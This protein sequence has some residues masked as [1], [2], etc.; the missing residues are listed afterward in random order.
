M[1]DANIRMKQQVQKSNRTATVRRS[2]RKDTT[3]L[4]NFICSLP[5]DEIPHAFED[6]LHGVL[7]VP[8][9]VLGVP[10]QDPSTPSEPDTTPHSNGHCQVP[11]NP[12]SVRL[13]SPTWQIYI[14][15]NVRKAHMLET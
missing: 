13:I 14:H 8:E 1:I 4:T 9:A 11:D 15:A 6:I 3:I 12:V 5:P 10:H 2:H 7:K